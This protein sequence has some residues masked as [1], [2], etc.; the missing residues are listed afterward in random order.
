MKTH[1]F[2]AL[3]LAAI[4]V[5]LFTGCASAS[6]MPRLGPALDITTP[7]ESDPVAPTPAATPAQSSVTESVYI[8]REDAVSIALKHAGLTL[9]QANRLRA[10][11]DYDHGRPEYDVD[12]DCNG[13]AYDYE[14]HAETGEIL[15]VN[16]EFDN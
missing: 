7:R 1:F 11:F 15:S 10:E 14:I 13:Y 12:F 3:L 4:C 16:K 8:T 2:A 6:P 9:N 5:T